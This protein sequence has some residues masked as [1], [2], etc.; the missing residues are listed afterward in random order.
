M[1]IHIV[2]LPHTFP[3]LVHLSLAFHKY[4]FDKVILVANGF[5]L[6][7][8]KELYS[9]AEKYNFVE[10]LDIP[11]KRVIG[12]GEALNYAFKHSREDVFCFADHDIFPTSYV[13]SD[14]KSALMSGDVA[15]LGSR[16]EN[17]HIEYKGFAASA[18]NT[19][20]G[21]PLATS[22]FS[23]YKRPAL[24][25]IFN[26]Y[27]IGFEQYFR[28]S[29][30]PE[31]LKK[32]TDIANLREP[33]LI[34][35]GKAL[36]LALFKKNKRVMHLGSQNVCHLGGLCGAISR[37]INNNQQ[38][39]KEFIVQ[40]LPNKEELELFYKQNQQRHPQVLELKRAIS[41][42]ALQLLISLK[43]KQPLPKFISQDA[44]VQVAVN[45]I[46]IKTKEMFNAL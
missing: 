36:S 33:F 21:V 5:G 37:L 20:S 34:D 45:A 35:T 11:T 2:Q 46:T 42:Y 15:C 18:T 3:Y 17:A 25:E 9:F 16:P 1:N 14:I 31:Y 38:N 6:P 23:I 39:K 32:Q 40:K 7:Q 8:I 13:L 41:D 44:N 24:E 22:F 43:G 12:H 29:Q 10:I 4:G 19:P 27:N 28:K 26:L 30:V